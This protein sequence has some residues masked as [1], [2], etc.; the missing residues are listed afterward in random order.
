MTPAEVL[1]GTTSIAA[2][3]I[4]R[5]NSIGS[6]QPGYQA[7]IAIIDAID[8]NQWMYHFR[9]NAC[10]GVIKNGVWQHNQL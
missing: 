10:T 4:A 8:I 5:E 7:D 3:A 2:K 6:L 9:A 1:K